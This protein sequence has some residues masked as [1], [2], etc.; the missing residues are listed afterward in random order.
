[1]TIMQVPTRSL[2]GD[3]IML[4]TAPTEAP[5][6]NGDGEHEHT[7]TMHH[8]CSSLAARPTTWVT[9]AW[10]CCFAHTKKKRVHESR[11]A[12]LLMP[13]NYYNLR[14][15]VFLKYPGI[16]TPSIHYGHVGGPSE[17]HLLAPRF[18]VVPDM[19]HPT[20]EWSL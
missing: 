2:A 16:A 3:M 18:R 6:D 15:N 10:R 1:M 17:F 19:A 9:T 5:Y 11:A 7:I 12:S 4:P 13:S 14:A 20:R 8:A